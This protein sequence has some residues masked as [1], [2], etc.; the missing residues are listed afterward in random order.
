MK[1]EISA[2]AYVITHFAGPGATNEACYFCD[3][4]SEHMCGLSMAFFGAFPLA[5]LFSSLLSS[6]LRK[7]GS[8]RGVGWGRWVSKSAIAECAEGLS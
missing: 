1:C 7:G 5:L 3:G 4:G 2:F 8:V 6:P